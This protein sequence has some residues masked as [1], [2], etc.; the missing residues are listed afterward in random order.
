MSARSIEHGMFGGI[1]IITPRLKQ[2]GGFVQQLTYAEMKELERLIQMHMAA[3][4]KLELPDA[5]LEA[6]K[7]LNPENKT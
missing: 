2:L 3:D 1:P 4:S 7:I 6:A 5:L